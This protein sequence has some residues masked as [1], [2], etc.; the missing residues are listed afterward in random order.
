MS[1]LISLVIFAG[2]VFVL[3]FGLISVIND[4]FEM[5]F[6]EA[7][8]ALVAASPGAAGADEGRATESDQSLST[9]MIDPR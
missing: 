7:P 8:D 4:L 5:G 1:V 9:E 2:F 6:H 3:Y